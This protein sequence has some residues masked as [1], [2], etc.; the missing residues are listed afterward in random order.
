MLA[1]NLL[2]H[3]LE[4]FERSRR[5]GDRDTPVWA[6]LAARLVDG[7]G[8]RPLARPLDAAGLDPDDVAA[9]VGLPA[10]VAEVKALKRTVDAQKTAIERLQK[11]KK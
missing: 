11:R 10:L 5:G 8:L 9:R 1:D 7:S 3:M 4:D 6:A 2:Q